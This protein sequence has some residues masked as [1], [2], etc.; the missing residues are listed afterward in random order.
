MKKVYKKDPKKVNDTILAVKPISESNK[1]SIGND[2]TSSVEISICSKPEAF[3]EIID[4]AKSIFKRDE[5]QKYFDSND[6][7]FLDESK[8][9][10]YELWR[11]S[12]HLT[13]HYAAFYIQILIHLGDILK[14]VNQFLDKRYKGGR[15][16][17][18]YMKWLSENFG[19]SQLRLLQQSR[20]LY[21]MGEFARLHS[22]IGKNRLLELYRIIKK[23]YNNDHSLSNYNELLQDF[24]LEKYDLTKEYEERIRD[25]IFKLIIDARITKYKLKKCGIDASIEQTKMIALYKKDYISDKEAGQIQEKLSLMKSKGKKD[26]LFDDFILNKMAFD[27]ATRDKQTNNP[28]SLTKRLVDLIEYIDS[29]KIQ[30]KDK[31]FIEKQKDYLVEDKKMLIKTK[32][33][34][35]KLLKDFEWEK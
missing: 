2:S 20:N 28:L 31:E 9:Q 29:I 10:I 32:S 15:P 23:E 11:R 27:P 22:S 30:L 16:K 7:K 21:D 19:V 8:R 35:E 4:D 18:K 33:V 25:E 5:L 13:F 6:D 3:K 17:S 14:M 24:S 34:I 1:I 26:K 12:H